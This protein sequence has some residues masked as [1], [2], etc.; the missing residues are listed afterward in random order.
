MSDINSELRTPNSELHVTPGQ[1][2]WQR[3]RRNR[4]AVISAWYLAFLLLAVLAWPVMLKLSG[5][6]FV[7][8]H[9]PNRLADAQ[10]APPDAQHWVGTK[11]HV[12]HDFSR[13]LF[14]AQISL[15]VGVV[16]AAV[17]LVIGVLWGAI[18]GYIGGRT[19]S[20][21]MRIVDVL[22]SLPTIIFVIVLITTF[23]EMLKQ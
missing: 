5:A 7:Q 22:Y 15:F 19:D 6:A 1:R 11:F 14:G 21:L 3:F 16:G 8:A 20:A 4:A 13:V 17:S 23:G 9:D 18:A 2:A 12:R 10:F